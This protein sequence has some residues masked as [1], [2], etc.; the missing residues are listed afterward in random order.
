MG[1]EVFSYNFLFAS[2]KNGKG[3]V[4]F[5]EKMEKTGLVRKNR[6]WKSDVSWL[7]VLSPVV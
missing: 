4:L 3:L 7:F 5:G 2:K 1:R 6:C